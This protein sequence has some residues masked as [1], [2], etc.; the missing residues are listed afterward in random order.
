MARDH[1]KLL[2][3]RMADPLIDDVYKASEQFPAAERFGLQ[4]QLRRAAVSAASN[5]VEGC[6]RRTTREYVN[7][8]NV[9]AGSASEARYLL[10]VAHRLRF[11]PAPDHDSL[12]DR[13]TS[14]LKGLQKLI[15]SLDGQP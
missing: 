11:L 5:I 2:V 12:T 7:L 6:A 1:K 8:L 15:Q 13:Y 4:S 9:A 10:D 3:F 14:L